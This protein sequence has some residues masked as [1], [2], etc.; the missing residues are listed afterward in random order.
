MYFKRRRRFRARRRKYKK[1]EKQK[2]KEFWKKN[3]H[4]IVFY[5]LMFYI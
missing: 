4:E 1:K 3:I 2:Q 5:N